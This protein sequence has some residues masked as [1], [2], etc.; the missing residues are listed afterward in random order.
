[1]ASSHPNRD[2]KK[3]SDELYVKENCEEKYDS[4]LNKIVQPL[5]EH[6]EEI[7]K[8]D[9][10]LTLEN[11]VSVY[12]SN[13]YL[14]IEKQDKASEEEKIF[15]IDSKSIFD[16]KCPPDT[17]RETFE[18][19]SFGKSQMIFYLTVKYSIPAYDDA[20]QRIPHA[21]LDGDIRRGTYVCKATMILTLQLIFLLSFAFACIW[22][23]PLGDL[24]KS[25]IELFCSM[26]ILSFV[27]YCLILYWESIR[28]NFPYN[29]IILIM[30]TISPA[31]ILGFI[32][33]KLKTPQLL[34]ISLAVVIAVCLLSGMVLCINC[35]RYSA[36][37]NRIITIVHLIVG[38]VFGIIA[39]IHHW[40]TGGFLLIYIYL[41]IL[42]VIDSF[43][44]LRFA[45]LIYGIGRSNAM[46]TDEHLL[47]AVILYTYIDAL[48]CFLLI[49]M[50][51]LYEQKQI[52]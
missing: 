11:N 7:E 14:V 51:G 20:G 47:T 2:V 32:N 4:V 39:G 26:C 48:I 28:K 6:E 31:L 1:M 19:K 27:L 52:F 34:I 40:V 10:I 23:T 36:Q 44:I 30:F 21:I 3:S 46:K 24:I 5:K 35:P 29:Y 33:A 45:Q 42:V 50:N 37:T 18:S 17:Y 15:D 41:C 8:K 25:T 43:N 13:H 16:G 22:I 49:I 12:R 38:V 9:I